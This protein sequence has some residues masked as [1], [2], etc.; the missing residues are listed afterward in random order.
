MSTRNNFQFRGNGFTAIIALIVLF[1]VIYFVAKGVFWLLSVVAPVLLILAAILDYKV[2][3]NYVKWVG[4]LFQRDVLM[5]IGI[6]ILSV[7]GYPV[8]FAILF[9]RALMSKKV[10]D[11]KKAYEKREG[12]FIEYEEVEEEETLILRP[13]EKQKEKRTSGNEY[14]QMF[15]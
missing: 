5:G 2:I 1:A 11:A 8:L 13:P 12:E 15:D 7:I 14:D 6:S 9:F 3:V 10:K 4:K